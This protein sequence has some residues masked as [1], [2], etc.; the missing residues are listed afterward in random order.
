MSFAILLAV[1]LVQA[2]GRRR[3]PW[4]MPLPDAPY[5]PPPGRAGLISLL[6]F[7]AQGPFGPALDAHGIQV[8]FA[9]P[10]IVLAA[11]V[12]FP[13]VARE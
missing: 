1:N 13:L 10:G 4:L 6:V 12:T 5:V 2:L 9:L 11:V 8:I 7:G 3:W